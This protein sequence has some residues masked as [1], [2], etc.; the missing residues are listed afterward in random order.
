MNLKETSDL[1]KKIFLKEKIKEK[2]LILHISLIPFNI[3]SLN[4]VE[5]FWKILKKNIKNKFTI[6]MPSFSLRM[7]KNEKWE[8]HKTKSEMGLL[9]E[10]FRKKIASK[11]SIHP[12][13]SV[14]LFGPL[15]KKIPSHQSNS[16]FGKGSVWEWLCN[17]KQVLNVSIGISLAG[18][19]TF[20]HHSEEI[21]KV[22]YR[23]YIKISNQVFNEKNLRIKKN[24]SF[25]GRVITS[26]KEGTNDWE[27]VERDLISSKIM[28][29]KF[30]RGKIIYTKTNVYAANK[31]LLKKLKKNLF[32]MGQ[33]KSLES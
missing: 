24:F 7:K 4:D 26:Q 23:K 29:K 12:F 8:Y 1:L 17:N 33:F 9:S 32:Y 28:K 6:I 2:F 3:K 19:A 21:S 27:K 11:R 15:Y 16:S 13:H 5:I 31:F 22:P 10:Y 25:F 20:V 14:C 30:F 18:G